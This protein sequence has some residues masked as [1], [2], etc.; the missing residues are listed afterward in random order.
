M[1]NIN[2]YLFIC[3]LVF[4]FSSCEE[5]KL[6]LYGGGD[7]QNSNNIY[8]TAKRWTTEYAKNISFPYNG[9][10]YSASVIPTRGIDTMAYSFSETFES[11][12][13]VL[14]PVSYM[15]DLSSKERKIS[16]QI[17]PESSAQE[18]EDYEILASYVPTDSV[19]GGILIK[20]N[21][22]NLTIE[23]ELT[24]TFK[25]LDNE[26]FGTAFDEYSRSRTES[27]LVNTTI[28]S[29]TFT[30][31]WPKP[32]YWDSRNKPA[33]GEW[34][35]KKAGILINVLGFPRDYILEYVKIATLRTTLM[36]LFQ[37]YLDQMEAA[38][39]PVLEDD[40]SKMTIN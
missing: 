27:E 37:N 18:G 35:V 32:I 13:I 9:E 3:C 7:T 19:F 1:K 22:Q 25:L 33:F 26:Y 2:F 21:K 31:G 16:Y 29:A 36:I 15:G 8:F 28:I 6:L 30:E 4:L 39:T 34:S 24:I 10:N 12:I 11:E 17:D 20:F 5:D 23:N 40:G 14:V 38:G